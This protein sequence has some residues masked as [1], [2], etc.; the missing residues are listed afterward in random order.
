VN[1]VGKRY[2][3]ERCETVVICAKRGEGELVCH[4]APMV[5]MVAKPLPSS[6]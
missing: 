5:V 6:D 4:G 3:C 2:R 1:Q